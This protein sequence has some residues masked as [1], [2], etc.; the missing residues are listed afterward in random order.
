MEL[1]ALM[2]N[3]TDI[4]I[5]AASPQFMRWALSGRDQFKFTDRTS[6]PLRSCFSH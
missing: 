6:L 5:T 1:F 2:E 4:M 3:Y